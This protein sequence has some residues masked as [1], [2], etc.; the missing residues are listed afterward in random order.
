MRG[1]LLHS[2][3]KGLDVP[4]RSGVRFDYN[5]TWG[6]ASQKAKRRKRILRATVSLIALA[7]LGFV[8]LDFFPKSAKP[9]TTNTEIAI[10]LPEQAAENAERL[11]PAVSETKTLAL[12]FE[13][14]VPVDD[15]EELR[16]AAITEETP[17]KNPEDIWRKLTVAP[18]DNLS[19]IFSREGF[20]KKDLHR[21]LQLGGEAKNLTRI[22]P[23]QSIRVRADADGHIVELIQEVDYLT[24]L[25]V[26]FADGNYETE[27]VEVEPEIRVR[28]AVAEIE[29]S[30]YL[31]GQ[32]AN[33]SDRTI[34]ALTDIFGWDIDF[35]LDI[36]RGDRFSLIFEEIYKDDEKVREGRILAAEFLNRN[37]QLRAVYYKNED[38]HH[39]YYSDEGKAMQKAFLRT[40][41]NFSRISSKFNLKRKHP[42]LN[43]IRAHKGVDYAAPHGTPIRATANGKIQFV[44]TKGGYGRTVIMQH[45]DKY[46]TL[47]AHMSR[48]GSGI[49]RGKRVEQGQTIGYVGK[50]GLATGPHL[51][52]EFRING[53]HRNP[54]TVEL[55]QA[56]PIE[57]KYLDDFRRKSAPLLAQL[58]ALDSQEKLLAQHR[59]DKASR[60]SAIR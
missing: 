17:K 14:E 27:L 43:R 40:P 13:P 46:S 59:N 33:L 44:G 35:V 2:K 58:K 52:Y 29:N 8:A 1:I 31:S 32:S 42:V 10:A 36:R 39:G 37:R 34:M 28:T 22:K 16:E 30:L 55:P 11:K 18:G 47:Y 20:S 56:L 48:F 50:T 60:Q 19:L 51:H 15:S 45:G 53:V 25:H 3:N 23:G 54:L 49:K 26:N 24:S 38:G 41:V 9:R 57:K 21:I 4:H 6:I 7:A 5:A 12:P